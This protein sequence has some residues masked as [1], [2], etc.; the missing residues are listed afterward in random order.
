MDEKRL[1]MMNI[2]SNILSCYYANKVCYCVVN[3]KE[4]DSASKE[5]LLK[6]VIS[7]F[8]NLSTTYLGDIKNI[9][10]GAK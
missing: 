2:A 7:M 6:R 3:Q 5:E 4:P 9:A 10:E 1:L 8:E